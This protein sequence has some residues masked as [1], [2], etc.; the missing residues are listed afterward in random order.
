[1]NILVDNVEFLGGYVSMEVGYNQI[2]ENTVEAISIRV[3]GKEH[4]NLDSFLGNIDIRREMSR[5]V[6]TALAD[7]EPYDHD[8]LQPA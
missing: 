2:D 7:G 1:M 4:I 8:G 3:V 6:E 5:H